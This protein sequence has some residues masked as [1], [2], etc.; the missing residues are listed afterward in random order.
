[1]KQW[2]IIF[3]LVP[4]FATS[5]EV[6]S[7]YLKKVYDL[8]LDFDESKTDSLLYYGEFIGK[9]SI[10]IKYPLGEILALRLKGMYE[11][12]NNNYDKAISL[13]LQTLE[14]SKKN[15]VLS[16]ELAATNDLA[17]VYMNTK[18]PVKAKDLYLQAVQLALQRN[19]LNSLFNAYSNTGAI[20]NQLKQPDSALFFL[21]KAFEISKKDYTAAD[22]PSL[23]NNLG[24][25]YFAKKDYDK[26]LF[27]FRKNHFKHEAE[28]NISLQWYDCLNMA[29]A[30]IEKGIPDSANAHLQDCLSF[31]KLLKSQSKEADTY[32]IYAKYYYRKNDYKNAY[33][34]QQLWHNLDSSLVNSET[35][36]TIAN[37]QETFNASER[38]KDNQLLQVSIEK[39]SLRNKYTTWLAFTS[40]MAALVVAFYLIQKRIAN[41][42]LQE[43]NDLIVRQNEKLTELN[44]EKNSL[45]SIVSHD[46]G[47]PLSTIKTWNEILRSDTSLLS[48]EQQKA[49]ERI[50]QSVTKGELLIRNILDVEKAETNRQPVH[51]ENIELTDLL[52][53][54]I[55]DF[56]A[57]AT[58]KNIQ[59]LTNISQTKCYLVSD[60]QFIIRIT[61]NLLSNAIKYSEQNKR[62][63]ITLE[64]TAETTTI[65]F[66]DEGQGISKDEL[67]HLFSKYS[68]LSSLPTSGEA[69]TGLGLS[70]VK[71]LADELNG[72]IFCES[73]LGKGSVFTV[74]FK[75]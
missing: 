9:Q 3:L 51:L 30:F 1:V 43:K 38:E 73:E 69:S 60:K 21:D 62:V 10:A 22:L 61:E 7:N 32:S 64:Q 26:S 27:F 67:P 17:Y 12:Y 28:K 2:F 25:V 72:T 65:Q 8:C 68:K 48:P 58:K 50:H 19:T 4:L 41:K 55:E 74:I 66:K 40:L 71:R 29:E 20:Y 45:I 13:Y 42:K 34:Y 63:W 11:E 33:Y 36:K 44:Y 46:L 31:A 24:S 75:K 39:A 6:D 15:K 59:L 18:Q 49:T 56:G 57:A 16:Y 53:T 5:Q 35:N 70:I 54:V 47:T 23:Y 14:L 37:L 52:K